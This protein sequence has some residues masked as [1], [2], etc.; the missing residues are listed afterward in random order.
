MTSYRLRPYCY[1]STLSWAFIEV[2]PFFALGAILTFVLMTS[3]VLETSTA[4]DKSQI[5]RCVTDTRHSLI[6]K[7]PPYV[8]VMA[9]LS[10]GVSYAS[11]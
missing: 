1:L 7:K 3:T 5:S 11:I 10:K 4:L 8:T 2:L 6:A 9:F